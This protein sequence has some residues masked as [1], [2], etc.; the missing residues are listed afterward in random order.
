MYILLDDSQFFSSQHYTLVREKQ[1]FKAKA[2]ENALC[3]V[4]EARVSAPA[5]SGLRMSSPST[6]VDVAISNMW[7]FHTRNAQTTQ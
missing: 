7:I 3:P 5:V 6:F 4:G 2:I 1:A